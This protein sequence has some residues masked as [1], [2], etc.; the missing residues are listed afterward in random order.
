MQYSTAAYFP[1]KGVGSP[2]TPPRRKKHRKWIWIVLLVAVAAGAYFFV[3]AG[4]QTASALLTEETAQLRDLITYYSF[5]GNLTPVSDETQT[6]KE[7]LKVRDL[8]V[9]EGDSVQKGDLLLRATDGTRVYA[10]Y[11]GVIEELYPEI[12]DTL[13]AGAQIAHIVDYDTLEVSVDVDEY[14]IGAL[15][16]GKEGTV[17]LNALERSVPGVVSEIARSATSE[18][19]V[20]YYEVKLQIAAPRDVRSGMSVEVSILNQQAHS[21]VSI[22][23][24]ALMYDE[25]NMPYVYQKDAQGGL[26]VLPVKTGV[27]DGKNIQILSGLSD[28]DVICYQSNDF[29]RFFQMRQGMMGGN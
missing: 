1:I 11:S 2:M 26:N 27:S 6:A 22:S 24:D 13:Q 3:S 15:E 17:Y 29:M 16:V 8:Y 18:G 25:Y 12:D 7:T 28:G 9:S 10:S 14:D 20:S 23:L 19:G 4:Q 21:A 5:S